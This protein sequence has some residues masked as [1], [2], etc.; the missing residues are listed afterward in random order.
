MP[1]HG[2]R[3]PHA[4]AKKHTMPQQ[5]SCHATATTTTMMWHCNNNNN[6][7][8]AMTTRHCNNNNNHHAMQRYQQIHHATKTA[9]HGTTKENPMPW[10]KSTPCHSKNHATPQQQQ[11]QQWCDAA[12][13]TTT[14]L[15]CHNNTM[16]HQQWQQPCHAKGSSKH[17]MLQQK[18][19]AM[20]WQKSMPSPGNNNTMHQ[21]Q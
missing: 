14:T 2:K 7:V 18:K 11:Q 10:Q 6:N 19:H 9:C 17:A 1:Q 15:W 16:P 20:P 21:Q 8:D 5:K 4:M 13:T 3:E 12:T